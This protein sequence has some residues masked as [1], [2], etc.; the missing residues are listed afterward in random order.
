MEN[1]RHLIVLG[2]RLVAGVGDARALGWIGRVL[3]R[4]GEPDLIHPYVLA[5]PEESTSEL[6][7]RWRMEAER[8]AV[9]GRTAVVLGISPEDTNAGLTT[10]R[11]RLNLANILDDA[12]GMHMSTFVVGPPPL[13][14]YDVN[15]CAAL[16]KALAEVCARRQVPYVDTFSPLVGHDEWS[17]DVA[18]TGMPGQSGYGLLAWLVLNAGFGSWLGVEDVWE[19]R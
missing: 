7:A 18:R 10:P 14:T 4:L 19:K 5:V 17:I 1:S 6:A 3:A 13:P 16:N 12:A 15:A 2:D 9:Y 11:S 8:R